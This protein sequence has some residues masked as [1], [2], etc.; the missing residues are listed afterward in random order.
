MKSRLF[1][2]I[3]CFLLISSSIVFSQV[4][5]DATKDSKVDIIDALVVAQYY[6]GI[7]VEPFNEIHCDVN[8]DIQ[9][10][11]ID[12]LLIAQYYVGLI[13]SFAVSLK[14]L[15]R[16]TSGEELVKTFE[17]D[18]SGYYAYMDGSS[19]PPPAPVPSEEGSGYEYSE[20][21]V[22][23]EG[24]DEADI[25]KTDG[26]YIY[27]L[28]QEQLIIA[29]AYPPENA[30]IISYTSLDG[31][32]PQEM[33]IH[34]NRLLI[35]GN[36]QYDFDDVRPAISMSPDVSYYPPYASFMTVKLFDITVRERPELLRTIDLEGYY[37]TSRKIDDYAYF[38]VN[39]YPYFL[40]E[41]PIWTDIVPCFRVI[42]GNGKPDTVNMEPIAHYSEIG[43]IPPLQGKQF[44]IVASISLT[45]EDDKIRNEVIVGSA[46]EAYASLENLYITQTSWTVYTDTGEISPDYSESTAITKFNIKNGWIRFCSQANV[47]GHIL[48]QFSMDEFNTHFRI[49][50][51]KGDVWDTSAP[52][53]N[54]VYILDAELDR[55]GALEGLAPGET[56]YSVR[57]AGEK[58][59][60]V[61]F[62]KIDPF[63]VLD[64]SDHKNPALLGELKIPG[65]SDYLHPYDKNHIIGIGK[66]AVDADEDLIDDRGFGFAWFQGVKMA[67]F[68]VTDPTNPVEMYTVNIG[69]RGT[70]SEAL[71]NHKAFLFDREKEIL[72]IPI[73]LAEIEGEPSADNQYGVVTFQGA[74]VYNINLD[75]GFDLKGRIT[76][77]DNFD[78]T[79]SY[80]RTTAIRR[81]LYIEDVLYS[82]S[83]V[84]LQLN[85]L[86]TLDILKK[87]DF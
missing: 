56:I 47:P 82:M 87:L 73:T 57:F 35:F 83:N 45:D 41:K 16:F 18:Q 39:S 84:R 19:G 46:D 74:Y 11:I 78:D 77:H 79:N 29:A 28:A 42:Q 31:V 65:Y 67:L 63:F 20:T 27:T 8:G 32:I 66:D 81:S 70:D 9:L 60:L 17:N 4:L 15:T 33:F 25:I 10:D 68:D 86:L 52:S 54:N 71:H 23:V 38:V 7:D 3:M 48:N 40:D 36:S 61:T 26:D 55:T 53:T 62:K 2:C 43:Y 51:T 59:Y 64:L 58:G 24:V 12:A 50:T 80:N 34:G 6:V 76:H 49:A 69:D 30:E 5:G 75:I 22:Q 21:N 44:I 72:V 13:D 1:L 14:L 37:I 85:D